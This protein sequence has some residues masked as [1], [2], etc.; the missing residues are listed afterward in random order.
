LDEARVA[1]GLKASEE[2]ASK[3]SGGRNASNKRL[4]RNM[5]F[6]SSESSLAKEEV[7]EKH[8]EVL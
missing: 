4:G 5:V 8:L 6:N 2:A 7:K 1:G 3:K